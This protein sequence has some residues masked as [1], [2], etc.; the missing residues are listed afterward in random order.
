MAHFKQQH[1][2]VILLVIVQQNEGCGGG[3]IWCYWWANWGLGWAP[4]CKETLEKLFLSLK[5]VNKIPV[6]PSCPE[7]LSPDVNILRELEAPAGWGGWLQIIHLH[8][9]L[10]HGIVPLFYMLRW[11]MCM[12][13]NHVGEKGSWSFFKSCHSINCRVFIWVLLL[14]L[15]FPPRFQWL[16]Y[17]HCFTKYGSSILP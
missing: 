1:K 12:I 14:W 2:K 4:V 10:D 16:C 11:A 3:V 9:T 15:S 6:L 8:H 17:C 7:K 5:W 13:T